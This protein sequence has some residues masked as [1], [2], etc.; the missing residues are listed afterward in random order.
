MRSEYDYI[1]IGAGFA[2]RSRLWIGVFVR[3][4]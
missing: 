1:I 4:P 2:T 3:A